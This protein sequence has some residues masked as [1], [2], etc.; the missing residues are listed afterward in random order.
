[1]SAQT[2]RHIRRSV[3]GKPD[4]YNIL[5]FHT[6]EDY[7]TRLCSTGHDFYTFSAE[8]EKAWDK[9]VRDM[10]SNYYRLPQNA[11]YQGLRYDFILS[12]SKVWQ[13]NVASQI[14]ARLS[15]PII[16]LQASGPD[17]DLSSQDLEATKQM[18]GIVNVFSTDH[19][20]ALWGWHTKERTVILGDKSDE[21]FVE[22]WNSIFNSA[23]EAKQ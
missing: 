15:I 22:K 16:S 23:Y 6:D 13:F 1:M 18:V 2:L 3:F 21:E 7:E 5:L 17:K 19:D 10:P 20:A 4:K 8:G 11:I 9:S 14:Q 12:Q